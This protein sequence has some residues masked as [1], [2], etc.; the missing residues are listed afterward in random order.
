MTL[1]DKIT[2]DG[3]AAMLAQGA[4]L[5]V[6]LRIKR[7]GGAEDQALHGVNTDIDYKS[8]RATAYGDIDLVRIR[9]TG[10]APQGAVLTAKQFADQ[11]HGIDPVKIVMED[12]TAFLVGKDVTVTEED[13]P[14]GRVIVMTTTDT[15]DG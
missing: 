2:A 3:L 7:A 11:I 15:D 13:L 1:Q 5:P 14:S 8:R 9:V 6:I 4:D 12:D 10:D